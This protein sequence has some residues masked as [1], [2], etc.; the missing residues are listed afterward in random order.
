M[1]MQRR[2]LGADG[3]TVAARWYERNGY[4]LVERNWR[5]R[6][7]ELD[8][9]A[10][11]RGQLVVCEV[12]TRTSTRFGG[13]AAAVDWRKQRTI[14]RGV[15]CRVEIPAR[16]SGYCDVANSIHRYRSCKVI[17]ITRAIVLALPKQSTAGRGILR[18]VVVR[19]RRRPIC[20]S[21][22]YHVAAVIHGNVIPLVMARSGAE[23]LF[24]QQCAIRGRI[25]G[26]VNVAY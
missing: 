10:T 2:A 11:R 7:G 12:K 18:C 8:I 5:C 16:P 24:P 26:R 1:S 17:A 23:A 9:I 14:R 3:E 4:E 22:Y 21:S 6:D 19:V 13:G 25:P 20:R 15:L